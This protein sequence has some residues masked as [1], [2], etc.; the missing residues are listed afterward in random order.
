M[1]DGT[2]YIRLHSPMIESGSLPLVRAFVTDLKRKSARNI[3]YEYSD[4]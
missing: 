1:G 2:R 4:W 3:R